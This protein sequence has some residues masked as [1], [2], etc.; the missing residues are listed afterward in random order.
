[1]SA[2]LDVKKVRAALMAD[3]AFAADP[4]ARLAWFYERS[5]YY[6]ARYL[7]YSVGIER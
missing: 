7:L 6:D 4:D 1:M 3:P 2:R 5:P